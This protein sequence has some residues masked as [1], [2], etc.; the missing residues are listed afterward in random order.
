MCLGIPG[1]VVSVSPGENQAVIESFGIRNKVN[2]FLVDEEVKTGDYLVV[3][4]GYAIG[5]VNL[6]EAQER[7]KLW[8]EILVAE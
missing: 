6:Q 8:E 2:I 5:K 1:K 3:H 4:A 7:L